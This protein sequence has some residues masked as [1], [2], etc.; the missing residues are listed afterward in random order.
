M[1][2][3]LIVAGCIWIRIGNADL[4]PSGQKDPQ[5]KKILKKCYVF[6]CWMVS[7]E[8]GGFFC[9]LNVL[10]WGFGI[11]V[12][13]FLLKKYSFYWNSK[14]LRTLFLKPVRTHNTETNIEKICYIS[15]F[16]VVDEFKSWNICVVFMLFRFSVQF[17]LKIFYFYSTVLP[18]RLFLSKRRRSS[19][20]AV[21]IVSWVL[22]KDV[23]KCF[24]G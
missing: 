23:R 9:S 19:I 14:I 4:D 15:P 20:F 17:L 5:K 12:L 16:F 13:Q 21:I 3:T 1:G 6:K 24:P 2:S 22:M 7:W 18:N 11:N 10:H 8:A